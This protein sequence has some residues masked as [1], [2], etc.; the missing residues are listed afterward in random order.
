MQ[1][2]RNPGGIML[3]STIAR[4]AGALGCLVAAAAAFAE[5][6][7]PQGVVRLTSSASVEV[8]RDV[9]SIAFG[10][11]R[12]GADA[13]GVQTQLKQALDA[14]LPEAKKGAKP[15]QVDVPTGPSFAR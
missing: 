15:G 1:F 9:L 12:E 2:R 13:A 6:P 11:N 5:T 3:L 14:A 10:T 7:A 4:T 8:T